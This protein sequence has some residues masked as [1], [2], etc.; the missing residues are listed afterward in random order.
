MKS[1][2]FV[3]SSEE[4]CL[5]L[6]PKGLN[7]AS[8]NYL[9]IFLELLS[10]RDYSELKVQYSL[11]ISINKKRSGSEYKGSDIFSPGQ[12]HGSKRVVKT[13]VLLKALTSQN[14]RLFINC[15]LSF[16][17]KAP[18][19]K[20]K[21]IN[22]LKLL[23]D[24]GNYSDSALKVGDD[25]FHVHKYILAARSPVFSAMFTH[26]MLENKQNQVEITDIEPEIMR[27]IL[28][29]IYT[30]EVEKLEEKAESLLLAADKYALTDLKDMCEKFLCRNL[31][32][33]N[34]VDY[35][36]FADTYNIVKLKEQSFSYFVDHV[37]DVVNTPAFKEMG[38]SQSPLMA[39]IICLMAK[40]QKNLKF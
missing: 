17:C 8:K 26:D 25:V 10:S 24:S 19:N 36:L 39:Q 27:E 3:T 22:D 31:H 13:P 12:Q 35:V 18:T 2:T 21:V 9:S 33:Q 6:Y 7:D 30:G 40:Q 16:S 11:S 23:F 34:V 5:N 38:K 1:P 29:F 15:S 32:V 37:Q 28:R 14:K 20:I 4:W